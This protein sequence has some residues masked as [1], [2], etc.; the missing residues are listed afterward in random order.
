MAMA[1]PFDLDQ[2]LV[3]VVASGAVEVPPYPAVALQIDKLL[4]GGDYGL[5]DL[6]RLVTSDQVLAA[7]MLRVSNSAAYFRSSPVNSV[8]A[9]VG[10]LGARDVARLALAFGLGAH[11]TAPGPLAPLRRR[12]WLEALASA[13]LCQALARGRGVA[14]DEAFS[15][16]L[17]HDFGK[18]VAIASIEA[19]VHKR[20]VPPR[21]MAEWSALVDRYHVELGVVMAARWGLPAVT[22]DVISLHHADDIGGA[23]DPGLVELVA[24][25]DEVT[26]MLGERT[27]VLPVDLGAAALLRGGEAEA[28]AAAIESL[29]SFV[30]SFEAGEPFQGAGAHELVARPVQPRAEPAV[31]P[32]PWPVTLAVGGRSAEYRILGVA[33]THFMVNGAAPLPENLLLEM[34]VGCRP[35][36]SGFASVKLAWPDQGGFTMLVQPYALS[37][38]A[39]ERW[40]QLVSLPAES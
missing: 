8:R 20:R 2:A 3:D 23:A 5:E 39:L 6:T 10:R 36:L 34:V 22:A 30:A 28:V 33:S 19:L 16:G 11:A 32:P 7:E 12:V 1:E 38:V 27:H 35:P 24:A 13:A 40:K 15:A 29:A 4:R 25:I 18:V 9:A 21:T 26:A 14:P 37:G 17:L 31:Q